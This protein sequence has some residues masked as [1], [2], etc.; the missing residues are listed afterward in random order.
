MSFSACP[1][2]E[3]MQSTMTQVSLKLELMWHAAR[4][5]LWQIASIR[6]LSMQQISSC[7]SCK[8]QPPSEAGAFHHDTFPTY[9]SLTRFERLNTNL[10]SMHLKTSSTLFCKGSSIHMLD[11]T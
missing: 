3:S 11:A 5:T 2:P 10:R 6:C 7:Q 8:F 1:S 9:M 4:D